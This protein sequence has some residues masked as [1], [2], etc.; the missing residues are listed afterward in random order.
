MIIIELLNLFIK[1]PRKKSILK[2]PG[3]I[4][5]EG[6]VSDSIISNNISKSNS[7]NSNCNN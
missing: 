1:E 2:N 3:Q 5:S 4:F 7:N 6:I